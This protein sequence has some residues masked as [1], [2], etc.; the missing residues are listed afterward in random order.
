MTRRRTRQ[1]PSLDSHQIDIGSLARRPTSGVTSVVFCRHIRASDSV[2]IR[3]IRG[4]RIGRVRLRL[5][6]VY[7]IRSRRRKENRRVRRAR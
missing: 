6:V 7:P 5:D 1:F 4:D 3:S 2:P